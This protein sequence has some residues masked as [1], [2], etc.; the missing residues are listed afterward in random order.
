MIRVCLCLSLLLANALGV[1]NDAEWRL[2]R[3][4]FGNN[5]TPETTLP[6]QRWSETEHV[7]WKAYVPGRGASSPIV[8]G[9]QVLVTTATEDGQFV[10]SY[11]RSDGSILW[12]ERAHQGGLPERLHRKNTAATPTPATD[13]RTVYAAFHNSGRIFLTAI[14]LTGER[15]WQIEAGAYECDYGYGYAPSPTLYGDTVIVAAECLAS[16]FLAAFRTSDGKPIWRTDRK[17]K[18]S[19]SSPIVAKVGGRDQILLSGATKVSAYDPIDGILLWQVDGSC[20]ATCGTMVWNEDTV[21]ASGG[22]PNKETLGV[23]VGEN[24][25]VLWKNKDMSY[26]QSLLYH[27]GHLYTLNDGGIAVCWEAA[28]GAER[29][30]VRLGGPVSAS[31]V[32]AAG[33][34]YAMNER[35]IMHVFSPDPKA[36]TKFAENTLGDEGFA[37]PAFVGREIFLRTATNAGER[38]E[39]LYCLAEEPE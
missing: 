29:W 1:A 16:G 14:R 2:W 9:H 3:G 26:E 10:L 34:I 39:W 4:P 27:E 22:F 17:H 18:T 21:F 30:R 19:Y 15:L 28:T 8:T 35:G 11:A 37:T 5:T 33:R 25:F 36:F 38:K 6:P 31:P 13:G 24:P 12:K 20:S 7:K 32:L 23:R